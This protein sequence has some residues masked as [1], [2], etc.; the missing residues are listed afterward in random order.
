MRRTTI[1]GAL[2][3]RQVGIAVAGQRLPLLVAR[4]ARASRYQR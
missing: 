3:R 4:P 1:G 2:D